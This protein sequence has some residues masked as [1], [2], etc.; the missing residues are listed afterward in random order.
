MPETSVGARKNRRVAGSAG[1]KRIKDGQEDM[2]IQ[3]VGDTS[4]AI[5]TLMSAV[6]QSYVENS[7]EG[8]GDHQS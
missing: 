6:M 4:T 5:M 2:L 7:R 8:T 1:V 3:N